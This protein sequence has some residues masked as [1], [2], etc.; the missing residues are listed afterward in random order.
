MINNIKNFLFKNYFINYIDVPKGTGKI[1]PLVVIESLAMC[2]SNLI[3]IYLV[4]SLHFTVFE[5]G[6]LISILSLGTCVGS[7][8]SGYLTTK[9]S[10]TKVSSLGLLIYALG[11][12]FLSFVTSYTYLLI[13][14]FL[15]GVGGI[16]MMI[17]NLTGLIKLADNDVMKNRII[18]LQSVIF[19]LSLSVSSFFMSYLQT[20][21]IRGL[22][23]LFGFILLLS[24]IFV[25]NFK[26]THLPKIHK[27][28]SF[29]QIKSNFPSI[30]IILFMIFFYGVI[31]SLVKIYFPVEAVS[32]FKSPFCSWLILSINPLMIIFLQPL[33]FDKLKGWGNTPLL[34][35]GAVL[36]GLGYA[37]FGVSTY[38]IFCIFFILLA[39]IGEMLFSPISKKLAATSFGYGNEGIGLA[40]WKMTYYFSGVL[41]AIFVGY[42]GESFKYLNVWLVCIPLSLA[43]TMS[44]ICYSIYVNKLQISI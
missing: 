25:L 31:Y 3:S 34:L 6:K 28:I 42:L 44:I 8:L 1:I 9:I 2:V 30:I 10:I 5:V 29:W 17:G 26:E 32:R 27:K 15:C 7:L 4:N 24:G 16:F 37:L 35:S 41:G 22:F 18:V 43:L 36:L 23:L 33:L 13:I 39:T 38:L 11:F 40:V 14:L 21:S 19:N 20:Q 12:F